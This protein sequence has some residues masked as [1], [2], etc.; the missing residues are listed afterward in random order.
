MCRLCNVCVYA[1]CN[2]WVCLGVG[3]VL[4][5]CVCMWVV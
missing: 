1:F 4:C 2:V 3:C 5:V